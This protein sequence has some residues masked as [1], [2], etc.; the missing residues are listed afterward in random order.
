LG[1][2]GLADDG[3]VLEDLVAELAG[4]LGGVHLV[5]PGRRQQVEALDEAAERDPDDGQREDDPGAAAAADAEGHEAEVVAV[6]LHGLLLLQEPL[7]PKLVG[8]HPPLGVVGEEPRVHQDLGLGGDVVAGELAVGEVHVRHQQ[9]DRHAQPQRLLH[10]RLQV[11]Q[12][13]QV[14]LRH[15]RAAQHRRH[16]LPHL[17]LDARVVHQLRDSP[18]DRPQ[19]RLDSC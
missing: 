10:H 1:V 16:L 15:R 11:R 4:L 7:R 9:R 5:H 18:F 19:R 8:A 3:G 17:R 13:L 6:R 2:D 12:P 14:R